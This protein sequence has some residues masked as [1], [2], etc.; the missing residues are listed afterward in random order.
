MFI[1]GRDHNVNYCCMWRFWIPYTGRYK[2]AWECDFSDCRKWHYGTAECGF[3][4]IESRATSKEIPICETLH[5]YLSSCIRG[6]IDKTDRMKLN[7]GSAQSTSLLCSLESLHRRFWQSM[8][9]QLK[10]TDMVSS[11]V[12]VAFNTA[13]LLSVCLQ[14][15]IA[16]R[17]SKMQ[18]Q[19]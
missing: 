11:I 15:S 2:N 9:A 17:V 1:F 3:P 14:H 18:D 19:T 8:G 6:Q 16:I 4:N 10:E 5:E 7:F 12:F 13:T